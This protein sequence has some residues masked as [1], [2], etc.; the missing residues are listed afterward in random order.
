MSSFDLSVIALEVITV[1][2]NCNKFENQLIYVIF[3]QRFIE[4]IFKS[5]ICLHKI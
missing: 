4:F 3:K 5:M 1:Q 2:N